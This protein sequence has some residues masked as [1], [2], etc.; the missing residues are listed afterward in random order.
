MAGACSAAGIGGAL[1]GSTLAAGASG[2][3]TGMG[4][5]HAWHHLRSPKT[6]CQRLHVHRGERLVDCLWCSRT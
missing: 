6:G 1:A 5:P 3:G 4:P 2:V